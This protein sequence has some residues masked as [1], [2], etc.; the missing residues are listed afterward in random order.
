MDR[1]DAGCTRCNLIKADKWHDC[2]G[3]ATSAGSSGSL[4]T[5]DVR[6]VG[7]GLLDKIPMVRDLPAVAKATVVALV[8]VGLFLL[9]GTTGCRKTAN[10]YVECLSTQTGFNCTSTHK[11][12]TAKAKACWRVNVSCQNGT[13]VTANACQVVMPEQKATTVIPYSQA[14]NVSKCDAAKALTVENVEVT[15]E[16]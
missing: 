13:I 3:S 9:L 16:D 2:A 8:V 11:E 12:G 15:V 5:T 6:K 10:V 14:S 4:L 7:F 1:H